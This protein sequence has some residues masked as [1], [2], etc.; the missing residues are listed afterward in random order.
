LSRPG[1]AAPFGYSPIAL[2]DAFVT[3]VPRVP[4]S[5]VQYDAGGAVSAPEKKLLAISYQELRYPLSLI[6]YPSELRTGYSQVATH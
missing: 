4:I 5:R 6:R 2:Q 3:R 1:A